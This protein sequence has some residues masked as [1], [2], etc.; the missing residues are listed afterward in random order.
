MDKFIWRGQSIK[1]WPQWLVFKNFAREGD[2]LVIHQFEGRLV[3]RIG[4]TITKGPDGFVVVR[5]KCPM[6]I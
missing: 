6:V 5:P 1:D 3:V 2:T 4:E